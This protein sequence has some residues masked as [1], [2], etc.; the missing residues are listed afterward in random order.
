MARP[1]DTFRQSL[2]R[3]FGRRAGDPT[4]RKAEQARATEAGR[5]RCA[6]EDAA[7]RRRLRDSLDWLAE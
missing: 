2:A 3:A 1:P 6:V 4:E 7:E 5:T